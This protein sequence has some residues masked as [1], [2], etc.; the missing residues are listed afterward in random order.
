MKMNTDKKTWT[1]W[2]GEDELAFIKRF[3]IMSGSLKALAE[4]YGVTYPTLRLRLDRLIQKIQVIDDQQITSDF[5]RLLRAKFTEGA[6]DGSTLK[7]LL[8]AYRKEMETRDGNSA[9][10]PGSD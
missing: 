6:I 9:R 8:Q 2:L 5:E 1:D 4:A 10:H 3:V 7:A